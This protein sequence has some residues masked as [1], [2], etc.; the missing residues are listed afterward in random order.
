MVLV[1]VPAPGSFAKTA[2]LNGATGRS[3]SGLVFSWGASSNAAG[4]EICVGPTTGCGAGSTG[5]LAAGSNLSITLGGFGSRAVYYWQVRATNTSG[6]ALANTGTW[7]KFTT[8]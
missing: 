1:T 5:W 6:T 4:Y 8:A 7:W 3:R 2:P